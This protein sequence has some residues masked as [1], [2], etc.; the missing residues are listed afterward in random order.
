[1]GACSS[2]IKAGRPQKAP[3]IGTHSEITLLWLKQALGGNPWS[4]SLT[5]FEIKPLTAQNMD[6]QQ[7][8]DG[9]G[10]SGSTILRI[11]LKYSPPDAGPASVVFKYTNGST[12]DALPWPVRFANL[13]KDM[14]L[15]QAYYC[16]GVF[17][18]E[19]AQKTKKW[20]AQTPI[21]YYA[22]V[23]DATYPGS[24][25]MVCCDARPK[26]VCI[27]IQEDLQDYES[28]TPFTD[29]GEDKIKAMFL[30]ISTIH[31]GSWKSS[32]MP[33][34]PSSQHIEQFGLNKFLMGQKKRFLKGQ[35]QETA[36]KKFKNNHVPKYNDARVRNALRALRA[37]AV[38]LATEFNNMEAQCMVH[39]DFHHW[40]N[41]C[42]KTDPSDVTLI[43]WQMWGNGR[44][45]REIAYFMS[46]SVDVDYDRDMR[47]LH[48]YHEKLVAAGV[49]GGEGGFTFGQF[50]REWAIAQME[51]NTKITVDFAS[52]LINAKILDGMLK[53]PKHA[54]LIRGALHGYDRLL[55]RMVYLFERHRSEF[56][57]AQHKLHEG[58]PA[59]VPS[60]SVEMQVVQVANGNGGGGGAAPSKE[61][62]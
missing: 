41:M 34:F 9:G 58:V 47:L 43:D 50:F 39:G 18:Q 29:P 61:N 52:A 15:F 5:S 24:C 55:D 3:V 14:D 23:Q 28:A 53:N 1:M 38:T 57:P 33:N 56:F 37:N 17:F 60:G 30:N 20:G 4:E 12:V 62:V 2:R 54:D 59:T 6:G 45:A 46:L 48:F 25:C 32:E 49:P 26:I 36:F 10:L 27:C 22:G 8:E 21:C 44:C 51:W 16:E 40:N 19:W 7:V 35:L 31:A 11:L 42:R 13:L